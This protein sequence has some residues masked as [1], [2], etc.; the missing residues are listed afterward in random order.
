MLLGVVEGG[1]GVV[2]AESWTTGEEVV[3]LFIRFAFVVV[4][5]LP[6]VVV[7][8]LGVTVTSAVVV[9][10]LLAIVDVVANLGAVAATVVFIANVSVLAAKVAVVVFAEFIA[11]VVT[12]L[13]VVVL[14]TLAVVEV[15][16]PPEATDFNVVF[17]VVLV[18]DIGSVTLKVTLITANSV[19][20]MS[21]E[22]NI[23]LMS[24]KQHICF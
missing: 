18:A 2:V 20:L 19:L 22:K 17:V 11:V 15:V 3:V 9:A 10:V 8:N 6:V 21:G 1:F 12:T 7:A 14:I 13:A 5:L 23:L 4:T 16:G 24:G